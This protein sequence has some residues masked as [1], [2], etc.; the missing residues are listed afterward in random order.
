[1]RGAPDT[2]PVSHPL[3]SAAG[4]SSLSASG[5]YD[6]EFGYLEDDSGGCGATHYTNGEGRARF[7]DR[8]VND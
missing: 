7:I 8:F 5:R 2:G 3:Q 6:D 1:M 4:R